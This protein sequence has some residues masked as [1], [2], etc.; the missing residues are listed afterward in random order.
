ME[1]NLKGKVIM[2]A[3]ASRGMGYAIARLC[4]LE[5][6]RVSM[7]SRDLDAIN[8]AADEIRTESGA[9]VHAYT[10]DAKDA[11]SITRW[12]EQ[13]IADLG[14]VSGLV[15]NAGGP[16][17]GQFEQFS[18]DDWQ[19]AFELSLMS[20]VRLI[21]AVLPSMKQLG[22]G[23]VVTV[24]STSVK[25]PIDVLLLSNVMR[26]GTTALVKSLSQHYGHDNIRFNNLMPGLIDTDR[27]KS[28]NKKTAESTGQTVE[29]I[30]AQQ[31]AQ[32]PM[33]RYGQPGEF[34]NAAVFLL[35]DASSYING[36]TLAVDG[37]KTR[38]V[39]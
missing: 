26:S 29:E 6:A 33:G 10:F 19:N 21:R 7:A 32:L 8:Q 23:S 25:E 1:L 37:S 12:S 24:T 17:A 14:P 20:G 31:E 22:G 3:A 39:W 4:A 30:R 38:T 11:A 9:E 34:A 5:G 13:T 28:L 27:L 36:V 35:S 16:P 2:V 18:D 15:V